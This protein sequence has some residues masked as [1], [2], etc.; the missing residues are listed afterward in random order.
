[1]LSY[2]NLQYSKIPDRPHRPT[3]SLDSP[4]GEKPVIKVTVIPNNTFVKR[5][6]K[7]WSKRIQNTVSNQE[8]SIKSENVYLVIKNRKREKVYEIKGTGSAEFSKI[9]NRRQSKNENI[10]VKHDVK[11]LLKSL[12][13]DTKRKKGRIKRPTGD[14]EEE[15]EDELFERYSGPR[16]CT[17]SKEIGSYDIL[18]HTMGPT[19]IEQNVKQHLKSF[20]EKKM[21]NMGQI[22]L[23]NADMPSEEEPFEK[24]TYDCKCQPR[25]TGTAYQLHKKGQVKITGK[26][27]LNHDDQY[28]LQCDASIDDQPCK[29][30]MLIE[31]VTHVALYY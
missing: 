18:A 31:Y 22:Q 6:K 20:H 25:N 10:S 14:D 8:S 23:P 26:L 11:Q 21:R 13:M 17:C 29:F 16:R 27:G 28:V 15:V 24:I 5:K 30:A 2:T 4:G 9:P 3:S 7:G 12:N 1:M 19:Q